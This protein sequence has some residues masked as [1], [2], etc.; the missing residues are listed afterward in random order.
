MV[1]TD[2][3]TNPTSLSWDTAWHGNLVFLFDMSRGIEILR[4][5]G[6]AAR[7]SSLRTAH[8]PRSGGTRSDPLAARPIGGLT[9]GS[10]VCPLFAI[11]S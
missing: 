4:L 8:E 1:G 2:A 6:G 11:P 10:L 9:R 3:Q 7:V 5:K